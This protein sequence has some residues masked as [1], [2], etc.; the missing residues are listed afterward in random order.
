MI[1]S[2]E[3]DDAVVMSLVSEHRCLLMLLQAL[4]MSGWYFHRKEQVYR[5]FGK[6]AQVCG[7]TFYVQ[8]SDS[9]GIPVLCRGRA[10]ETE[11]EA[12]SPGPG[13]R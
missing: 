1:Q 8:L 6:L 4:N 11:N 13:G 12:G 10:Q 2:Y 7:K 3:V 5:C 9:G